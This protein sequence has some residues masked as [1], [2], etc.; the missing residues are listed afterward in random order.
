[1]SKSIKEILDLLQEYIEEDDGIIDLDWCGE[2]LYPF[3]KHFNDN[4]IRY[5]S[6]SLI[7]FW[8][9]L[10]EWEDGSGFPF[11]T[12]IE[13]YDCHHF[14][15]YLEEFLSYSLDI[16]KQ[17]PNI[18]FVIIESLKFLDNGDRFEN[19]FPN[20]PNDLFNEVRI[21]LFQDDIQKRDEVYK[22]ALNEAGILLN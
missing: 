13:E 15:K 12:G 9:L 3:Y 18:Y 2:F 14:D 7:G 22:N 20:I 17:F 1:M 4:F 5:R 11:F 21:R 6:G 16:K 19:V 10:L 8:G